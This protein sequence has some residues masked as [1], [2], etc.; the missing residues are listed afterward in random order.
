[1]NKLRPLIPI[2]Q[3]VVY[4]GHE[5]NPLFGPYPANIAKRT[6][7]FRYLNAYR[8]RP[9]EVMTA[10][11]EE[12]VE[13][14]SRLNPEETLLVIPAGQSTT[15]DKVFEVAQLLFLK[16]DFFAKGG[17][18]YFTCGS[19]YWVSKTRIYKD[20]CSEQEE[21]PQI[22]RK[23]S[24]LALFDGI[25]EGPLCPFPG[26]KYKVGF[27]SDAVRVQNAKD[28]CTIF[29]SGGGSFIPNP[30]AD[31]KIVARYKKEE[32]LRLKIP[33]G[34]IRKW[35]NA[36]I[37]VPFQGRP[38]ML[39]SM[40]HPYYGPQDIDA[41]SYTRA[42][43]DSGTNWHQVHALLSPLEKRMQFVYSMITSLEFIY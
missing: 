23:E 34:E 16:N 27:F 19:A 38:A 17:R 22:I 25:A 40:F 21:N 24:N 29:L 4:R 28:E 39:L 2:M 9:W 33:E 32:L 37:V 7:M 43:P 35:E 15:L 12:L 14:L 8:S 10:S 5:T 6:E 18:G 42:F 26:K 11:G 13:T 20:L 36:A 3:V 30:G 31:V 41:E 1:M